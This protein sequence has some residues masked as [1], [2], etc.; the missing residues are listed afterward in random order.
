MLNVLYYC[1]IVCTQHIVRAHVKDRS[2]RYVKNVVYVT[3]AM[4]KLKD[5]SA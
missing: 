3:L 2:Y 4:K 5:S 1:C